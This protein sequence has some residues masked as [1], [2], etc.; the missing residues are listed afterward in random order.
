MH[1]VHQLALNVKPLAMFGENLPIIKPL[2]YQIGFDCSVNVLKFYLKLLK[3]FYEPSCIHPTLLVCKTFAI[4]EFLEMLQVRISLFCIFN[5]NFRAEWA[6]RP[7]SSKVA[8]MPDEVRARVISFFERI[9]A[10]IKVIKKVFP[11]PPG[12]SKK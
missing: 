5:G 7:P 10:N 6:I 11:V 8:A 1:L 2:R 9:V 4:A 3:I 12:A